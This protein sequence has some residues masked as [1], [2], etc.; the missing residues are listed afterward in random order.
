MASSSTATTPGAFWSEY[1]PNVGLLSGG[2]LFL[3]VV[4][5]LVGYAS[6]CEAACDVDKARRARR[7]RRWRVVMAVAIV[8]GAYAYKRRGST[9]RSD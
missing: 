9:I 7:D 3:G 4:Y 2:S 6:A 5:H 8:A 1:G